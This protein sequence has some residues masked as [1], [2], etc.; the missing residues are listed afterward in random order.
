MMLLIA[1]Q[2]K[3]LMRSADLIEMNMKKKQSDFT[4]A[5][6]YTYLYGETEFSTR[7]LFGSV[8]PFQENYEEGGVSGRMRFKNSI[9]LGY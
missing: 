3:R 4:M 8:M 2:E 9:Y 7:Y 1:G 6:A 5:E